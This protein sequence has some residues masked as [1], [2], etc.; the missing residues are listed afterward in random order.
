MKRITFINTLGAELVFTNS[1]PFLLQKF[2]ENESVTISS[3][4]SVGQ[5]GATYLENTLEPK[6]ISIEFAMIADTEPEFIRLRNLV[7]KVLSPTLGEGTLI[8]KDDVNER[9]IKCIINKK[10]SFSNFNTMV[11]SGIISLTANSP[12]WS[13]LLETREDV[14]YWQGDFEFPL[15]IPESGMEIGH[16]VFAEK[17]NLI[18]PG[19][20]D[21]GIRIEVQAFGSVVDPVIALLNTGEYIKLNKTLAAGDKLT[22]TTTFNNKR[23]IGTFGGV[24]VNAFNYIDVDSTFFRLYS[25]DNVIQYSATSGENNLDVTIYFLPLYSGV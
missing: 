21:C 11:S 19:D 15:E 23:V 4:K 1:A 9:M 8:Y 25:G 6:D 17:I 24:V 5:D 16:R 12:F 7:Y 20:I 22:I 3:S 18:N 14:A 13:T 2:T 10:P